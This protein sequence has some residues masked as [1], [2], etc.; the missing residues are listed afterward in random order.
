MSGD[1]IDMSVAK[2]LEDREDIANARR[3]R[4]A[5]AAADALLGWIEVT[6]GGVGNTPGPVVDALTSI[7]DILADERPYIEHQALTEAV[8]TR[9][10]R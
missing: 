10:Y 6:T 7:R 5:L 2:F 3:V 9:E 4:E 8:P 1:A